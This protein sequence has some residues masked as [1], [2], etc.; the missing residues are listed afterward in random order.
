[1]AGAA[2]L[3]G[4]LDLDELTRTEAIFALTRIVAANNPFITAWSCLAGPFTP[5]FFPILLVA[6]IVSDIYRNR[7]R[8]AAAAALGRIGRP[9]ALFALT[10][11]ML[12]SSGGNTTLGSG[13]VRQAV[14]SVLPKVLARVQSEDYRNIRPDPMTGLCRILE[15]SA[16]ALA[17]PILQAL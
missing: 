16:P 17:L 13:T 14:A 11:A 8:A 3:L 10:Q 15:I 4:R 7:V 1:R 2:W 9:Y 6:S 12:G 5:I